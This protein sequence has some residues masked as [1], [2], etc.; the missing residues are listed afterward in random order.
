MAKR[1]SKKRSRK[2]SNKIRRGG[3]DENPYYGL[4]LF[5]DYFSDIMDIITNRDVNSLREI[6]EGRLG[7][8][9]EFIGFQKSFIK[10]CAR[11]CDPKASISDDLRQAREYL[12]SRG[13][14]FWANKGMDLSSL[15]VKKIYK[16]F[17]TKSDEEAPEN[18]LE[19]VMQ[20]SELIP[21]N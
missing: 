21:D 15:Q 13:N 12:S 20:L 18:M 11:M 2:R 14:N 3:N 17:L 19:F 9:D 16:H 8:V 1:R 6:D 10:Q 5:F 7:S 4:K